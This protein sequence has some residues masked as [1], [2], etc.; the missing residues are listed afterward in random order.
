MIFYSFCSNVG[1]FRYFFHGFILET[2]HLEYPA[3]LL[4][5]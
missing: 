2:T 1:L 4:G 5:Q 3:G